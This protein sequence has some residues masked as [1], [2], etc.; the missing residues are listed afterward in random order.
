MANHKAPELPLPQH[1]KPS[2]T[3]TQN[4]DAV[5]KTNDIVATQASASEKLVAA[6]PYNSNK[7][8]EYGADNTLNPPTGLTSEADNNELSASAVSEKNQNTKTGTTAPTTDKNAASLDKQRVDDSR[9]ALGA[10][11]QLLGHTGIKPDTTQSQGILLADSSD[12]AAIAPAFIAAIT[13]HRYP[14]RDSEPQPDNNSATVGA[15]PPYV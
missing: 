6:M 13:A 15:L 7:I 2:D 1:N 9:Q 12:V 14:N 3:Q 5:L 4:S 8:T 10:S 11:Q